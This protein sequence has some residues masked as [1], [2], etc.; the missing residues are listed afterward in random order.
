VLKTKKI[1][2]LWSQKNTNLIREKCSSQKVHTSLLYTLI[3]VL[4]SSSDW[5]QKKK[6]KIM[7]KIM[8]GEK[9]EKKK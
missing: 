1:I 9:N 6:E 8:I 5:K 7:E 2:K 3:I 4:L